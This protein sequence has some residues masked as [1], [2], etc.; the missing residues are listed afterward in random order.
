MR[1]HLL[2][3]VN[4]SEAL[5]VRSDE[6]FVYQKKER[7]VSWVGLS[8][9]LFNLVLLDAQLRLKT[10]ADGGPKDDCEKNNYNLATGVE[11]LGLV[12]K[13]PTATFMSDNCIYTSQC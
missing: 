13:L 7:H 9:L 11:G 12:Y 1:I 4:L 6:Y 5:Y 8:S 10:Q 3:K 2:E